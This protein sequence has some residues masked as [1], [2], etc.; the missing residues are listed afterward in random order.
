MIK[1]GDRL[2]NGVAAFD[3]ARQETLK[4]GEGNGLGWLNANTKPRLRI[5]ATTFFGTKV[6]LEIDILDLRSGP[7]CG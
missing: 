2:E 4:H 1:E 3:L 6:N 5:G 7:E